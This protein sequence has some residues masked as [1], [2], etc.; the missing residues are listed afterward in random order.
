MYTKAL[1]FGLNIGKVRLVICA[2]RR[3]FEFIRSPAEIPIERPKLLSPKENKTPAY[4]LPKIG[5]TCNN[6]K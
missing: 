1:F 4:R 2:A 5:S 3:V 6:Q